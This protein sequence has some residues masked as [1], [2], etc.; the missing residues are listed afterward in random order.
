[1]KAALVSLATHGTNQKYMERRTLRKPASRRSTAA[2][3]LR[4]AL[5]VPAPAAGAGETEP[6]TAREGV[7]AGAVET[8]TAREGA[9]AAAPAAGAAAPA[10]GAGVAGLPDKGARADTRGIIMAKRAHRVYY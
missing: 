10:A 5:P 1:M 4:S 2:G 9:G 8:V 6:E 7:G 3:F